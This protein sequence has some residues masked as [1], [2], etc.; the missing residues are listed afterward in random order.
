MLYFPSR[1]PLINN[2]PSFHYVDK[3]D[4][5][6]VCTIIADCHCVIHSIQVHSN[7]R[8][9]I[10]NTDNR[11]NVD[12]LNQWLEQSNDS[13]RQSVSQAVISL[14]YTVML[15]CLQLIVSQCRKDTS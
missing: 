9:V 7:L 1:H 2:L 3:T 6:L 4:I 8:M 10:T 15:K 13:V 5:L 14:Q 11:G 12:I